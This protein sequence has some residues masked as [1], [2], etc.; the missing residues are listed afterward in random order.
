MSPDAGLKPGSTPGG[1]APH[2]EMFLTLAKA[3]LYHVP[4]RWSCSTE[5][6]V[7]RIEKAAGQGG[8]IARA[9]RSMH[10]ARNHQSNSGRGISFV[11]PSGEQLEP[12]T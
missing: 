11:L 4:L 1:K 2:P 8:A 12:L 3:R 5:Y 9:G 6:S 10:E 7:A